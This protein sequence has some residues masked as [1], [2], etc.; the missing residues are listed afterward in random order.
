MNTTDQKVTVSTFTLPPRSVAVHPG[1]RNGV[2][3][4]WKSPVDG[5]VKLSG[6]LTDADASGGDG[7]AWAIDLRHGVLTRG[8]A[9]GSFP[10][11]GNQALAG[12]TLNA[13]EVKRD[14]LIQLLVL[15]NAE[16]TCDT[17]HVEM[18]VAQIDGSATWDVAGDLLNDPLQA[19][20]HADR[21]GHPGVWSFEDMAD[22]SRPGGRAREVRHA[23]LA[24]WQQTA[25]SDAF[26]LLR[27]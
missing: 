27:H 6:R 3:V 19:N 8:L 2:V 5:V 22:R 1:P 17:T 23:P 11:G 21:L 9:A 10:N 13:I 7:I 20:P 12:T 25:R 24:A 4:S 16:Y 15:P 18:T 14:D 26:G